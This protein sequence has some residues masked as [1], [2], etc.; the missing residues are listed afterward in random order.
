[1]RFNRLLGPV[2]SLDAQQWTSETASGDPAVSCAGCG[3]IAEI[4]IVESNGARPTG[5]Y[6]IDREGRIA[7]AWACRRC[8]LFEY[9]QLCDWGT[10]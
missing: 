3:N 6:L 2:E 7:P 8:P 4:P 1:L 5:S 9:I 10:E